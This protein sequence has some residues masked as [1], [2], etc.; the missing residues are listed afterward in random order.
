MTRSRWKWL[1]W[2]A[3]AL[4]VGL[5]VAA[6]YGQRVGNVR[7]MAELRENPES[8]RAARTMIVTLNDGRELPV[9]YL[10]EG[11]VVFMGI[12]GRWWREF[13]GTGAPVTM[14]IQGETLRGH[15][16]V[17]LDDPAYVEDVFARLRPTAPD[18]L[19]AWLNG[20]LVVV[21]LEP[22]S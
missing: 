21:Q 16:R 6:W 7:V 22:G 10:R 8:A 1:G 4:L 18:W 9:N 13:R 3:A 19:P 14:E 5:L 12:D 17:V 11:E 15:G 2:S 20:R